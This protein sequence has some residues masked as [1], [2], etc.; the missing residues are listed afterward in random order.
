MT[1]PLMAVEIREEAERLEVGL[2][3][4][5][6]AAGDLGSDA[7]DH[8]AV[9]ADGQRFLVKVP[10]DDYSKFQMHVVLNWESL[11]ETEE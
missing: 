4:E 10:I 6:F 7:G 11:L 8:Y 1:G 9:S 2:L 5:L 3:T